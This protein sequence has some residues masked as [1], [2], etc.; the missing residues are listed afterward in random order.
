MKPGAFIVLE[1]IDGSGTT[2][3]C[4]RLVRSLLNLGFAARA[5]REP[6]SGSVG[7]FIRSVLTSG[8]SL[9]EAPDWRTMA[10]L[11]AA[12]RAD[13]CAREIGP[14]LACGE[15]VVCDR[16]LLSSVVYQSAT[17]ST[18]PEAAEFVRAANQGALVPDLTVVCDVDPLVAEQRRS[19]RGGTPELYEFESLQA[20]L[21][22]LYAS[23]ESLLPK[24]RIQHVPGDGSQDEVASAILSAVRAVGL[25]P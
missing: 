5:T 19:A 10:L 18:P 1:G 20:R 3:Q 16:Y 11:F 7:Q 15:I 24:H 17:S 25:A 12:D 23:A 2:T 9:A 6:S 21:A 22:R 4:D 13:H 14:S 8:K